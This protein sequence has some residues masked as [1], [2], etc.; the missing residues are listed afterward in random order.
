MINTYEL[1]KYYPELFVYHFKTDDKYYPEIFFRTACIWR[2]FCKYRDK[3]FFGI[4]LW[5]Y[6][7]KQD[8]FCRGNNLYY[9]AEWTGSMEPF[10]KKK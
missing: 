5:G 9:K 4:T 1:K 2:L 10:W 7:A 3:S 6:P 8:N